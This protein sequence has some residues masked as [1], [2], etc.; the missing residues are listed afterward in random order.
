MSPNDIKNPNI[1]RNISPDLLQL[2]FFQES[3]PPKILINSLKQFCEIVS[4]SRRYSSIKLNFLTSY[5]NK[6]LICVIH[7]WTTGNETHAKKNLPQGKIHAVIVNFG[8]LENFNQGLFALLYS[9]ESD[10]T[11]CYIARSPTQQCVI[12]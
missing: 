7:L 2:F 9:A 3:Y 10:S 6:M 8:F 5:P 11:V 4:I 1:E 12:L